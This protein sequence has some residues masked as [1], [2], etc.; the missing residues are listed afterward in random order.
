MDLSIIKNSERT[1]FCQF[2]DEIEV[3]LRHITREELREFY[4]K[5][6]KVTFHKN[7]KNE[8]FDSVK[9][10][11]LLG[12]AAI[13]SWK[14]F[15]DNGEPAPCTPENIDMLMTRYNPFVKWI[16]EICGD[17]DSLAAEEKSQTAKNC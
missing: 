2:N 16:N 5:A 17:I 11:C 15:T 12:R 13:K 14:G 6:T 7:Q 4:R 1:F 8:E 10:D 9:A 3:E